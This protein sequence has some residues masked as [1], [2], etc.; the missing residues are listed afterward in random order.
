MI[1]MRRLSWLINLSN[2]IFYLSILMN[3]LEPPIQ[4]SET[5]PHNNEVILKPADL[6]LEDDESEDDD[7]D[8]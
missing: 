1:S 7:I 8:N 2:N 3:Q 6:Q 4:Q 5:T